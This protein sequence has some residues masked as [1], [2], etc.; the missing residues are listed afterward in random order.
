MTFIEDGSLKVQM[1]VETP[2]SFQAPTRS[3]ILSIG[4]QRATSS[5]SAFGTAATASF[6][7]PSR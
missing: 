6:F 7:F 2:A 5:T 1:S 4:P 3:R